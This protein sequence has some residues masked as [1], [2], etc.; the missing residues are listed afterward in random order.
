MPALPTVTQ[1]SRFALAGAGVLTLL[2]GYHVRSHSA[3]PAKEPSADRSPV[4]LILG[5]DGSWMATVNQS[6][7]SVSLVDLASGKI[8]AETECG[9]RPSAIA[10][11]TDAKQL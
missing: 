11:S 4:D 2:I 7:H 3:Q 10:L 6:S 5:P 9:Q 8:L 1:W